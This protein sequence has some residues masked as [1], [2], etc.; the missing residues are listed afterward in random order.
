MTER[1]GEMGHGIFR[2]EKRGVFLF[3]LKGSSVL[4]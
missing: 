1:R 2:V 3:P 4:I